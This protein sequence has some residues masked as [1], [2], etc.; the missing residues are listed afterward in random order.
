[1]EYKITVIPIIVGALGRVKKRFEAGERGNQRKDRNHSDHNTKIGWNTQKGSGDQKRF[2]VPQ[3][4]VK[5]RQNLAKWNNNDNNNLRFWDTN[6]SLNLGQATRPRDSL[7]KEENL[8]NCELYGF[9]WRVL[10]TWGDLLSLKL[11][12]KIIN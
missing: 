6:R 12:W 11:P 4:P 9:G 5:D 8:L 1:M 2:V 7:L 3:T 10:K